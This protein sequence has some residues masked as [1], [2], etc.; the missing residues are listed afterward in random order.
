MT[1]EDVLRLQFISEAEAFDFYKKKNARYN[2]FAIR[3]S[4]V[5]RDG[6]GN[7]NSRGILFNKARSREKKHLNCKCPNTCPTNRCWETDATADKHHTLL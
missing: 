1:E 4:I 3:K 7:I 5:T 6:N 2:G